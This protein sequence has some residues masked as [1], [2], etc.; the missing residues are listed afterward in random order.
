MSDVLDTRLRALI[1]RNLA[2][3]TPPLV[4]ELRCWGATEFLPI[5]TATEATLEA[6]GLA[7]PFWA[8]AWPGG[9]ALA[10]WLL[11]APQRA[12]GRVVLAIGSGAGIEAV[13]AALCGA[14]RVVANDLDPAAATAFAMNVTLTA[15]ARGGADD[16]TAVVETDS[17]D[18]I[19]GPEPFDP[20]FDL[21]LAGDVFYTRAL[22][23]AAWPKLRAAAERGATVLLGDPDRNYLPRAELDRLALYD[24]PTPRALEDRETV[25]TAVWTPRAR[26]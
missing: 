19:G 15:E 4:P 1:R 26:A 14:R 13:A 20:S 5:W 8:F 18:L 2:P 10:R 22:A 23:E 12:E 25:S 11:D 24:V 16:W 9:Q 21:I 6:D 7:P 17:R 3:I